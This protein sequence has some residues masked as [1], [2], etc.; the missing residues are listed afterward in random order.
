[1]HREI[2]HRS[3]NSGAF[4]IATVSISRSEAH[5]NTD[6]A[7]KRW[8]VHIVRKLLTLCPAEPAQGQEERN[9]SPENEN[10]QAFGLG[11]ERGALQDGGA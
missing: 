8:E 5:F 11:G 1:M 7:G 3:W 9:A 10:Q 6:V 4:P 2:S